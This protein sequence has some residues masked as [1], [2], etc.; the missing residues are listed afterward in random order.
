MKSV[1]ALVL[2]VFSTA[3]LA[4]GV[5]QAPSTPHYYTCATRSGSPR[6]DYLNVDVEG[7]MLWI[8]NGGTTGQKISAD[9][10][11]ALKKKQLSKIDGKV[12][13]DTVMHNGSKI[14]EREIRFKANGSDSFDAQME[15]LHYP[16]FTYTVK[17]CRPTANPYKNR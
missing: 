11:D 2:S 12:Y 13:R 10:W 6:P 9:I 3:A 16:K 15:E 14:Y 8:E 5:P 7:P 17:G 1:F 4:D